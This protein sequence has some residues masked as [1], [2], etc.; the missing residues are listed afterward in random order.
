[1]NK[2]NHHNDRSRSHAGGFTLTEILVV[3]AIIAI[4]VSMLAPSV[5]A[6]LSEVR[7]NVCKGNIYSIIHGAKTFAQEDDR[8]RLPRVWRASGS[9]EGYIYPEKGKWGNMKEGNPGCLAT[10]IEQK[11][12]DRALYLCPEAQR[13]PGISRQCPWT[14]TRSATIPPRPPKA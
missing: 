9:T 8:H 5:V 6:V 4:L 14:R 1:M 10:L 3:I 2:T 7:R 11:M 13:S 12:T